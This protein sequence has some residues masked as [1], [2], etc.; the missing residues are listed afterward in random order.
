M[1]RN[2]QAKTYI[3]GGGGAI[4]HTTERSVTNTEQTLPRCWLR[5][6]LQK[7]LL[8]TILGL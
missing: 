3:G 2:Q 4:G 5:K 6:I 8:E 7:K 1:K